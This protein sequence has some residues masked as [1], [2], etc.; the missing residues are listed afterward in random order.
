MLRLR[1]YD[2]K[3]EFKPGKYLIVADT[4]SRAFDRSEKKSNTEEEIKAQVDMIRQNAQVSDP[5]WEKIATHA[6][7]DEELKDVLNAVHFGWES[8]HAQSLKPY[9]HFRGDITEI[10]GVLVKGPKVIIPKTLQ[11][12]M[13]KKIHEGHLGIEKRQARARQVMYWPNINND[14]ENHIGRCGTCQ[15]H[16]YKQ[17]KEPIEQHEV[18]VKPWRK[19]GADLFTLF[20][21]N[22]LV[23]VDYTSNYPEVAKLEDLSSTNTISHMKSIMARHGLPSVVVSDNGPQFS[24]REFRQFAMQYGFKHVTSSPEY[25]Q[26]NGKAEKAVQ[27]VKRLLKKAKENDEDPYLALL[28]YRTSPLLGSDRS[29]GEIDLNEQETE[30]HV[31]MHKLPDIKQKHYYDHGSNQ[32]K[33]LRLLTQSG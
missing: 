17:A 18:P 6:K 30:E 11:G 15:K 31:A 7:D 16:R 29:P 10:D 26:S 2:L 1:R 23:V 32:L 21:K 8:N 5:M 9:Y 3:L 19:I 20:G 22:F 28:N 25:P 13:L 27:I 4:L 24:S 12:D 14:I 33:P